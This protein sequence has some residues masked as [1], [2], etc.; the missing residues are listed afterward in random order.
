MVH[1]LWSWNMIEKFQDNL[2]VFMLMFLM[3]KRMQRKQNHQDLSSW[4][5]EHSKFPM[6][7]F[8]VYIIII[9]IFHFIRLEISIF[10]FKFLNFRYFFCLC[11]VICF[12]RGNIS[13]ISYVLIIRDLH[14]DQRGALGS[15]VRFQFY[16]SALSGST[17]IHTHIDV[18]IY[19]LKRESECR[20]CDLMTSQRDDTGQGVRNTSSLG[21]PNHT[22]GREFNIK[23]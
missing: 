12:K 18:Y 6:V 15:S 20:A 3:Q 1:P 2:L 13:S 10:S 11:R 22:R 19:L 23:G 9:H 5:H 17:H 14:S 21:T 4:D 8:L 16:F 7:L